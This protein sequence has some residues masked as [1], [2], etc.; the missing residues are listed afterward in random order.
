[1]LQYRYESFAKRTPST[2][3]ALE[4]QNRLIKDEHT[5]RERID[6]GK[7]RLALFSMVET[8][9][10]LYT[11]GIKTTH[12]D[13]PEL[14]LAIWTKG[15]QFAKSDAKITSRRR[16]N[17]IIYRSTTLSSIDDST[18]WPDFDSF[19]AKSF[20]FYNT[21]FEYPTKRENWL[22]S[23]C[24]CSEYF[25]L[26]VCAHIIGIAIRLKCA[27]PPA[28]AKTIPIGEKR[29]RGRPAKAKPALTRQ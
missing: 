3:T 19:K 16:G 23:E 15:Y 21:S 20:S 29:K 25:K 10:I 2:N 18:N 7:F 1:M 12:F 14:T 5:L 4:S 13:A 22:Q 24:D 27:A 9:A 17:T 11:S 6:L 8:W 26:F 28:E